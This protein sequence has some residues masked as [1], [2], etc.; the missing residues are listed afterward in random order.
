MEQRINALL[1]AL[2]DH[3]GEDGDRRPEDLERVAVALS[4]AAVHLRHRAYRMRATEGHEQ[5]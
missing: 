3:A 5:A 4:Q 1:E 2:A